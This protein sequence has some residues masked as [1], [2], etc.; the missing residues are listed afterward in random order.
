[1]SDSAEYM[2][3]WRGRQSGPYPIEEI[4]RLLDD[5]QI[6]LGHEIQHEDQ[7][8]SLE[9]F[10]AFQ[11][12][13]S[14]VVRSS[15]PKAPV[16]PSNPSLTLPPQFRSSRAAA[17]LAPQKHGAH[18]IAPAAERLPAR[19]PPRRLV[20]ALLGIALGF[21]GL[22]NYYARHWL[23]G[24]LQLLLSIATLLLGF[25]VI[26]PWLWAMVEA[27]VVRKDGLGLEML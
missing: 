17:P 26:A 5:H 18:A 2:L 24:L 7:W 13:A 3:R 15:E 12:P 11:Q 16:A 6:G 22:H 10:L 14:P 8:I 25:G 4:N 21:T 23:T 9:E 19:R 1:M 27:V 20:Y